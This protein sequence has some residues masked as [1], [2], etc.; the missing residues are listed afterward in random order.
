MGG[1]GGDATPSR[2]E[3]GSGRGPTRVGVAAIMLFPTERR[4]SLVP[5]R[6][7]ANECALGSQRCGAVQGASHCT[8]L[9]GKGLATLSLSQWGSV[10]LVEQQG[11]SNRPDA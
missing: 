10:E 9:S 3:P 7:A 5:L 11:C 8:D 6:T 1:V 4:G 2:A